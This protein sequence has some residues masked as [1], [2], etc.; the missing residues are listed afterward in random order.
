MKLVLLLFFLSV[1]FCVQA[2]GRCPSG[3][4]PI[5]GQGVG[6]C[7]PIEGGQGDGGSGYA[8]PTGTWETRWG[9]IAEDNTTLNLVTGTST[10][11]KSKRDAN[12][13]AIAECQRLGGTKCKVLI[14]YHNQCVAVADPT[15][16]SRKRGAA[17]SVFL[18]AQT[19]EL[20]RE[21][22]L[23]RCSD[24]EGSPQCSVVYSECSMSEFREFN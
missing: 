18:S 8:R 22:A 20:A 24:A 1:S 6:G 13:A 17:K 16:E 10:S 12:Q 23:S 5:G 14:S 21:K 9:A 11:R 3:Q 7:A 2:E 19:L 15:Q 4:Y